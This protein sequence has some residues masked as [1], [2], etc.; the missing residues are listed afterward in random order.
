MKKLLIQISQIIGILMIAAGIFLW[1]RPFHAFSV[2]AA[3][4]I[5]G[6]ADGPTAIFL[7]G[8]SG[9]G[10]IVWLILP[11]ILLTGIAGGYRIKEYMN[12]RKQR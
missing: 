10:E 12:K 4:T 8:K 11:G 6:R 2:P 9:G 1:F 7:A 3:V 5:I